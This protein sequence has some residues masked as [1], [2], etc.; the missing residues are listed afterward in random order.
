MSLAGSGRLKCLPW[1]DAGLGFQVHTVLSLK[2]IPASE[3]QAVFL[4]FTSPF[5]FSLHHVLSKNKPSPFANNKT[6]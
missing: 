6:H 5:F 4:H 2:H 3:S 1:N